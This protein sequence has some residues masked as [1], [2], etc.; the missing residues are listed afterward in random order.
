MKL[1]HFRL[2]TITSSYH[3]MLKINFNRW[4]SLISYSLY[5]THIY[6]CKHVFQHIQKPKVL[7]L[8][9][10]FSL[11]K[12]DYSLDLFR[13]SE[14]ITV[15]DNYEK[16]ASMPA[17]YRGHAK[18]ILLHPT[19]PWPAVVSQGHGEL[20]SKICVSMCNNLLCWIR[21]KEI[22]ETIIPNAVLNLVVHI[23]QRLF[24]FQIPLS[25]WMVSL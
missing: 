9:I 11:F 19:Q 8:W 20:S 17:S 21:T 23:N 18:M 1:F 5:F 10:S 2:Q 12:F 25:L 13:L 15:S 16:A 22:I 7:L 4:Y 14:F 6:Q 3:C 24:Y